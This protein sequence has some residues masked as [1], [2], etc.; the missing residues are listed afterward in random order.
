MDG[1]TRLRRR[2]SNIFHQP[3]F[4]TVLRTRFFPGA[5]TEG[6]SHPAICQSPRI[7]R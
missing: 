3:S 2:L 5:G 1:G 7:Q 4:V 6:S